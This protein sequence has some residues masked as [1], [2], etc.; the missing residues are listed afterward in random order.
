[1]EEKLEDL[2]RLIREILTEVADLKERVIRLEKTREQDAP[3]DVPELHRL[4]GE[5]PENLVDLYREGYH[6]CPV[7]YG[8]LRD[9]ECLFCVNFL[10]KRMRDDDQE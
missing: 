4:P 1:M 9:G 7:A 2:K 5:Q 10:E 3:G 6:V 8:R